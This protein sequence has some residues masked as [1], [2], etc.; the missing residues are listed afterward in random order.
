MD[1]LTPA[2]AALRRLAKGTYEHRTL[3]VQASLFHVRELPTI[4]PPDT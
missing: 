1:A 2:P 3:S 4:P